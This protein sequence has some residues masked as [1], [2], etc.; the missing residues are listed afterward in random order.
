MTD[1]SIAN[2]GR[3]SDMDLC[4][5]FDSSG[6]TRGLPITIKENLDYRNAFVGHV[7]LIN[8]LLFLVFVD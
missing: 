5:G 1:Q 4:S 3:N 2:S 7:S 6:S 8:I